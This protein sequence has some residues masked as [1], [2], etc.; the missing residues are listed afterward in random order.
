VP[1]QKEIEVNKDQ[2]KGKGKEAVGSA[3]EEAGRVTGNEDLE[4]KG[5]AQKTEGKV[6]HGVGT[7]KDRAGKLKDRVTGH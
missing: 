6:Q 5:A 2:V 7:V 1:R 3:R 4:A